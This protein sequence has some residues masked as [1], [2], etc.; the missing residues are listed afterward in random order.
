MKFSTIGRRPFLKTSGAMAAASTLAMQVPQM[1]LPKKS[2]A[3]S[4]DEL[5]AKQPNMIFLITDQ[6]RYPMHWP[7]GLIQD[8]SLFPNWNYLTGNS[9]H[10]DG[11]STGG[12]LFRRAY[13]NTA[14]CSPSRATLF[15]GLHP[16][17]HQVY[18]TLTE[19]DFPENQ[20]PEIARVRNM[21]TMLS[22]VGYHVVYKGKWH[23][24]ETK[25]GDGD[26]IPATKEQVESYGFL[27][28]DAM[29]SGQDTASNNFGIL[30]EHDPSYARNAADFITDW[31]ARNGEKPFAL[32]VSLVNPH[33]VL[34]YP[35]NYNEKPEYYGYIDQDGVD[36]GI[37]LPPSFDED[38]STK[39]STHAGQLPLLN[40]R[41]GR[42]ITPQQ[43][44]TYINFYAD[45][46]IKIE[47]NLQEVITSLKQN[48]L[49]NDTVV[50]RLSDHGEMGL[51]HGGM[52]QKAYTM[53]EEA[54]HVPLIISN[55]LLFDGAQTTDS[56]ASLID[57][58]P[59]VANLAHVP[60][61]E[62]W[63]LKG[64]DLTPIIHDPTATVQDAV[65]FTFDDQRA[66]NTVLPDP[67]GQPNHIRALIKDDVKYG[68][69]TDPGLSE[70]P[71]DTENPGDPS[72]NEYEMYNRMNDVNE[73]ENLATQSN[74]ITNETELALR[75]ELNALVDAKL[76]PLDQTS[77]VK[78]WKSY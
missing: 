44:L 6:Q 4:K 45:L 46:Q 61:I 31:K 10:E 58:M 47:E 67:V 74:E 24:S 69:Y 3:Q 78:E 36:Y 35:G 71:I 34:A 75:A 57:I 28:W 13:C 7:E 59:T 16:A 66:G 33:D 9:A 2:Q 72:N 32:F 48:D 55:P 42:L 62:K 68:M 60:N 43:R 27:E 70:Y 30:A 20:L 56:L 73:L 52:R 11:S 65:L 40:F 25:N 37:T 23:L 49:E 76:T 26:D 15:T 39:P 22:S 38:L 18:D 21:A 19:S 12:L 17:Q 50:F 29:E 64:N 54:I 1:I 63:N 8:S 5:L 14:M 51:S 53:Y 41:L 77:F